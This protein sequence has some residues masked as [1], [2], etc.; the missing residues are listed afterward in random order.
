MAEFVSEKRVLLSN[1]GTKRN[2]VY[3]TQLNTTVEQAE[4]TYNVGRF[5]QAL[6]STNFGGQALVVIP[7][8]SL[9]SDMYLHLELPPLLAN[10]AI[11][12]G[13]GY[14]AIRSISYLMGSA[15]VSQLQISG[16]SMLQ[17]IMQQCENSEKR[18]EIF[19]LGGE[20]LLDKAE[21]VG[22]IPKADIMIPLPWSTACSLMDK[23]PFDSNVLMNPIT[24]QI[25]F[26]DAASIYGGTGTRPNGFDRAEC[27]FKQGNFSNKA[28]SMRNILMA[29]PTLMLAYPFIHHQSFSPANFTVV[30]PL[31]P[32]NAVLQSFINADLLAIT[33]GIVETGSLRPALAADSP[34]PF[35][36]VD[37]TDVELKF[38][39]LV[40]NNTP[41]DLLKL[42]NLKG[43]PVG[44][45]YFHNDIISA[46]STD[47]NPVDT[48]VYTFDFS[49][50][51]SL[52]FE[53]EYQNVRR[54]G[55]QVL[56]LNF[57]VPAAGTYTIFAT[58]HY[59][60][61]A[62]LARG[63]TNIFFN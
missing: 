38:N 42:V 55:N 45:N 43:T 61:V 32:T 23:K 44:A 10:Q 19:R 30:D 7:N 34:S 60:G 21:N 41:G 49:R 29:K 39:G 9:L 63:Q 51:R 12:R 11:C 48:Y 2:D 47:S 31:N 36:Y 50:I 3:Y 54:I 56:E 33:L 8:S 62:E 14:G 4:V 13:W 53:G 40:M 16:Q 24:I 28:M 22:K 20:V 18:S 35:N 26:N 37:L 58:Y 25:T 57:K 46:G 6:N 52:C 1:P 15:N 17:T 27:V 5:S 59:N